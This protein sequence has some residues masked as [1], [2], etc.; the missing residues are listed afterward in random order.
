MK[1]SLAVLLVLLAATLALRNGGKRGRPNKKFHN[2]NLQE[3]G[4]DITCSQPLRCCP[5]LRNATVSHCQRVS[6]VNGR[7]DLTGESGCGC[8][9]GLVCSNST[10]N[11]RRLQHDVDEHRD[12]HEKN[13]SKSWNHGICLR[14]NADGTEDTT[15]N[16]NRSDSSGRRNLQRNQDRDGNPPQE[17]KSKLPKQEC[18]LTGTASDANVCPEKFQCCPGKNASA[19]FCQKPRK[20]NKSCDLD[21]QKGCGCV[22]GLTCV[23]VTDTTNTKPNNGKR[24]R[25]NK[26]KGVCRAQTTE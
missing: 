9:S 7:C 3:C 4:P 17:P 1:T 10:I 21:N 13:R 19:F 18:E 16:N 15:S 5:G 6:P 20:L 23:D 8:E 14:L 11:K 24:T 25:M 12:S 22:T 26:R 2:Q